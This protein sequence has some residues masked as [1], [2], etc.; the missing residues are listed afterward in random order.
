MASLA[1]ARCPAV[2]ETSLGVR[3][4]GG[5]PLRQ[6]HGAD[7]SHRVAWARASRVA[8]R[9]RAR[10]AQRAKRGVRTPPPGAPDFVAIDGTPFDR[11][12]R[13]EECRGARPKNRCSD[14][15]RRAESALLSAD[16]RIRC[17]AQQWC[18]CRSARTS[19]CVPC[20]KAARLDCAASDEQA[21]VCR[22]SFDRLGRELGSMP[23]L[24]R[25][26]CRARVRVGACASFRRRSCVAESSDCEYCARLQ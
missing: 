25:P 21:L 24:H 4:S 17:A 3:E 14:S 6:A 26:C 2:R 1:A 23:F 12:L 8:F 16:D 18:G 19:R 9:V 13:D 15:A 11:R 7:G 10:D 20:P 5:R 22:R